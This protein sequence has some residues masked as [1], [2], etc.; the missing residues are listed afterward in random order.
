M[1]KNK[2]L[3]FCFIEQAFHGSITECRNNQPAYILR[4]KQ[5]YNLF[6]EWISTNNAVRYHSPKIS[7][8]GQNVSLLK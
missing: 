5:C 6:L 2:G 3:V 8:I 1:S 7:L 4:V